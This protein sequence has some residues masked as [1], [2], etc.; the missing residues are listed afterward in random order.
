MKQE[1]LRLNESLYQYYLCK[2]RKW[3]F[4]PSC[5]EKMRYDAS[6]TWKCEHCGFEI[7]SSSYHS[8][9]LFWYCEKCKDL[10]N[11]Q[12]GFREDKCDHV[13]TK[14][15]H[16]NYLVSA[17]ARRICRGCGV[18]IRASEGHYCEACLIKQSLVKK[19][20]LIGLGG[21]ATGAAGMAAN[22][23][24]KNSILALPDDELRALREELQ[25]KFQHAQGAEADQL[26]LELAAIDDELLRRAWGSEKPRGPG[27]HREHGYNLM[28]DD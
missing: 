24:L 13:C 12:E 20:I 6:S 2:I 5:H 11:R 26:Y 10:L 27:Y 14:C 15:G 17:C 8:D 22:N 1:K 7:S 21:L 28:K 3:A 23:V 25:K 16:K 19:I 18:T 9:A 4:C